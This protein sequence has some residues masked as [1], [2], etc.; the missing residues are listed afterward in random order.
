MSQGNHAESTLSEFARVETK[1]IVS[2]SLGSLFQYYQE[3]NRYRLL[4]PKEEQALGWLVRTTGD[5]EARGKLI[6]HNLRLVVSIARR[7]FGMDTLDLIQEGNLGL[8]KAAEKF[9][10]RQGTRFSTYATWWIK[11]AIYRAVS[12]KKLLIRLPVHLL[13]KTQKLMAA[14]GE[15]VEKYGREPDRAELAKVMGYSEK[16]I[17][18]IISALAAGRIRLFCEMGKVGGDDELM[19]ITRTVPDRSV[20]SP[21]VLVTAES[22]LRHLCSEFFS[23]ISRLGRRD[24][25]IFILRFGL[26]NDFNARSLQEVADV[27]SLTRERIR[28][29]IEYRS[30]RVK[31]NGLRLD[32]IEVMRLVERIVKLA[33]TV[34]KTSCECFP[35]LSSFK[36]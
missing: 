19:D 5:A 32:Q 2:E 12:N 8:M 25:D 31:I 17:Q 26:D 27:F 16:I 36:K 18:G 21:E 30:P 34:G 9:D 20:I 33:E 3:M 13:A 6:C 14:A 7:C 23:S 10:D 1:E 15:F 24:G 22:E 4:T 35:Q 29:I 11:Q 28:Q